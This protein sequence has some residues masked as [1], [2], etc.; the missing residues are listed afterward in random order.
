[1]INHWS[2]SW[3]LCF[4][5]FCSSSGAVLYFIFCFQSV[6]SAG[7]LRFSWEPFWFMIKT[8]GNC[9][10][11]NKRLHCASNCPRAEAQPRQTE[12]TASPKPA[13]EY[14]EQ[15]HY[16]CALSISIRFNSICK[17]L[18][19][20]SNCLEY[21]RNGVDILHRFPSIQKTWVS[22]SKWNNSTVLLVNFSSIQLVAVTK[23][24]D[25]RVD[26]LPMYRAL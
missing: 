17:Q 21:N 16:K 11:E 9:S 15:P 3:S 20:S 12:R 13:Y 24:I 8:S 23:V 18:K 25:K 22:F 19:K 10:T 26:S 4:V 7:G 1:M 6:L 14:Y 5:L 2:A